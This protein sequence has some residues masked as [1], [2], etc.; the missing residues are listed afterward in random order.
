MNLRESSSYVNASSHRPFMSHVV[1]RLG[2]AAEVCAAQAFSPVSCS[3]IE[4][5]TYFH[6]ERTTFSQP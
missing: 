4:V 5:Q 1:D 2:G 3:A 6:V